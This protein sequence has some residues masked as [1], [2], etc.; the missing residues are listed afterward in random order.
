MW[1]W[2]WR[3][4][5]SSL[6]FWDGELLYV[7]DGKVMP[8]DTVGPWKSLVRLIQSQIVDLNANRFSW[9]KKQKEVATWEWW[10]SSEKF[11]SFP[12]QWLW[13]LK[14]GKLD[15]RWEKGSKNIS[16]FLIHFLIIAFSLPH[17]FFQYHWE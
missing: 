3:S 17:T 4:E 11:F 16:F 14:R 13:K 7:V 9:V 8:V 15:W 2:Y 1:K 10:M 6:N 5:P 12:F